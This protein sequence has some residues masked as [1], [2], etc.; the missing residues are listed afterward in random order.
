MVEV[1]G[2]GTERGLAKSEGGEMEE[3][4]GGKIQKK[5]KNRKRVKRKQIQREGVQKKRQTHNWVMV[6]VGG[7]WFFTF[8]LRPH[9]RS[10]RFF[11]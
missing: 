5:R 9:R 3:I 10:V 2:E 6:M 7:R 1:V 4:Y 8:F 11:Y